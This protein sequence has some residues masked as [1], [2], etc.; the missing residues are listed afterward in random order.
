[1]VSIGIQTFT[2]QSKMYYDPNGV[3]AELSKAGYE[4]LEIAGTGND[5]IEAFS[6]RLRIH[7]LKAKG[8][9]ICSLENDL[10]EI[11]EI[12]DEHNRNLPDL[13]WLVFFRG[14]STPQDTS[15]AQIKERFREYSNKMQ[16][17]REMVKTRQQLVYH[18]YPQDFAPI[19]SRN[20]KPIFAFDSLP[21]S[22]LLQIDNYFTDCIGFKLN[23]Y[24]ED[25]LRSKS[26]DASRRTEYP[27]EI[28]SLHL[29]FKSS[30]GDRLPITEADIKKTRYGRDFK[31]KFEKMLHLASSLG[32]SRYIVETD[33]IGDD[34]T[35]LCESVTQIHEALKKGEVK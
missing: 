22:T 16:K 31:G 11:K 28:H 18:L 1:V 3:L 20:N 10:Q 15:I 5:T 26:N 14:F 6:E 4:Y 17:I 35:G 8:A 32:C 7:E 25:R 19:D 21:E 9:H 24:L 13:E 30:S 12:I 33:D 27:N 29:S 23:S 2:I 34:T